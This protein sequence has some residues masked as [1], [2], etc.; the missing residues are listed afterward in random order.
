MD[1]KIVIRLLTDNSLIIEIDGG[2]VS[3]RQSDGHVAAIAANATIGEVG[4]ARHQ[5]RGHHRVDRIPASGEY[6]AA[7]FLAQWIS[8]DDTQSRSG[9]RCRAKRA[10]GS[11]AL[12]ATGAISM[13][14]RSVICR[15]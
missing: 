13:P 1:Q 15:S 8:G 14:T 5:R 10:N 4:Y 9:F 2:D 12:Q 11:G 3:V 6:L 7:R